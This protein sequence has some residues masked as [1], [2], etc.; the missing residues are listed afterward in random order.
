[1][2]TGP[3]TP[4][5]SSNTPKNRM[6]IHT[7]SL[8]CP[9]VSSVISR[10]RIRSSVVLVWNPREFVRN[11]NGAGDGGLQELISKGFP[12]DRQWPF[13]GNGPVAPVR[14]CPGRWDTGGRCGPPGPTPEPGPRGHGDEMGKDC[15]RCELPDGR[16]MRRNYRG[17]ILR[18]AAENVSTFK[19]N[20]QIVFS[21]S[22]CL[23]NT[24]G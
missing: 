20:Y 3:L 18:S 14:R 8:G 1:M 17:Y 13:D 5:S 22:E 16:G 9:N 4:G 12:R 21:K 7:P 10:H 11:A 15:T 23:E 6:I 19:E 24:T 2:V